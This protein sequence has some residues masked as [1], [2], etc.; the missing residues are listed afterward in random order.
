MSTTNRVRTP[1]ACSGPSGPTACGTP[2][3][4][5]EAAVIEKP[6]PPIPPM[7]AAV[8]TAAAG[9]A[10]AA[11]SA[12]STGAVTTETSKTIVTSA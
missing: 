4:R 8:R 9:D 12:T 2:R 1:L 7:A 5:R 3:Q 10:T 11:I 6:S